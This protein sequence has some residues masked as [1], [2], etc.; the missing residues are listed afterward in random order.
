MNYFPFL[1]G[2]QN[3]LMAV[4]DLASNIAEKGRVIPIIE[5][6][7]ANSTTRISIDRFIEESMPFLF[8]C[9][10]I[11][12]EFRDDSAG[13]K[14]HLIDQVL[15]DYDNWIPSFYVNEHTAF[16]QLEVFID[17]YSSEYPLALI[18]YGLPQR[19]AVREMIEEN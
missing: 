6:V 14:R 11:H 5:P 19:R 12:G 10:P 13:L 2:K 9:N 17:T 18:Y 3:E 7:N 15:I 1:R 8:I 16:Q 4:R